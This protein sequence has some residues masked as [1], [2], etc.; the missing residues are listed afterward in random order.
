MSKVKA[1]PEDM[2]SLT[3][4]LVCAGAAQAI[5]FYKKAFGAVEGAR[6]PGPDGKIMHALLRIGN[7]ALM[8]MDEA[9]A[10]GSVG[11]NTL[12]GSPVTIHLY[13]EDAD[14]TFARALEA[15]A[16]TKMPVTEMFWGDR[17]GV[18]TDPFGHSW[19]IATHVRDLTPEEIAA[20]A[21]DAAKH[22]GCGEAAQ[23]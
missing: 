19:S 15:G 1:I 14:A 16:T 7:S 18:L 13:V 5:D 6:M 10:W 11:P 4:H 12:K 9:P 21:A 20:A 8:L 22:G 2:H 23:Q 3:P 17:Y